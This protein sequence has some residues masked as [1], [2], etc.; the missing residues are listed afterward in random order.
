[1]NVEVKD[2]L[3]LSKGED[4][5]QRTAVLSENKNDFLEGTALE[6]THEELFITD[7]YEPKEYKRIKVKLRSGKE[8]WIYAAISS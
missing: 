1:M 2:E 7:Q 8:A 5:H 4:L 3:F 6:M